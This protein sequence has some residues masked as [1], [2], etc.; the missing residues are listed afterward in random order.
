M[1]VRMVLA[2]TSFS[3]LTNFKQELLDQ[4]RQAHPETSS[5]STTVAMSSLVSSESLHRFASVGGC[6]KYEV[7][8]VAVCNSGVSV[9]SNYHIQLSSFTPT[10]LPLPPYLTLLLEPL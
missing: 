1:K 8:Q 4:P 7:L 5:G 2:L 10:Y 9:S 3:L 6:K